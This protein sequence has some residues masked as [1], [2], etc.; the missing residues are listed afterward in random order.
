VPHILFFSCIFAS[1]PRVYYI[2]ASFLSHGWRIL[3]NAICHVFASGL[4]HVCGILAA[5]V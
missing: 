3:N 1:L 2:I 5:Y 4:P